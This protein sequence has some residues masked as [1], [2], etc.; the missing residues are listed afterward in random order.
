MANSISLSMEGLVLSTAAVPLPSLLLL[1]SRMSWTWSHPYAG[2]DLFRLLPPRL[3]SLPLLEP[4]VDASS[5]LTRREV[6]EMES[7]EL[8]IADN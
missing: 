2:P 8:L 7:S 5:G 3:P 6:E 1:E 4:S